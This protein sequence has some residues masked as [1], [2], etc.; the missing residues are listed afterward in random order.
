MLEDK[1]LTLE[2]AMKM[3]DFDLRVDLSVHFRN[4]VRHLFW[5]YYH[6]RWVVFSRKISNRALILT[7]DLEEALRVLLDPNDTLSNFERGRQSQ[8]GDCNVRRQKQ[9]EACA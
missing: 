2:K 8:K 1:E 7:K 4:G 5:D 6:E 9:E 3:A